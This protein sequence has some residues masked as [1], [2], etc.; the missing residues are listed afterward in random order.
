VFDGCRLAGGD[1]FREDAGLSGSS[2][3][4][5]QEASR[6]LVSTLA[7]NLASTLASAALE[8]VVLSLSGVRDD[9]LRG[10][11]AGFF[12]G[13]LNLTGGACLC[14]FSESSSTKMAI[15]TPI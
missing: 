11:G 5:P 10:I 9:C 6:D 4:L 13:A 8:S 3:G 15:Q 7:S 1:P 2:T 12:G 14:S